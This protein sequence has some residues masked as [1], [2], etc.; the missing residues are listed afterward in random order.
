MAK[1]HRVRSHSAKRRESKRQT[2][3]RLREQ[4]GASRTFMVTQQPEGPFGV[5]GLL[6]EIRNR[7]VSRGGRPS[8]S[9]P[10]V[11]RLVPLRK[12]VWSSLKEQAE[13]LSNRGK[14]VSPAQ[15]AAVLVEKSLSKLKIR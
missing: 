11:R 3:G 10:T 9:D 8:D 2:N 5:A 1:S 7:L 4:L 14:R 15:L 12:N 6:E 13:F